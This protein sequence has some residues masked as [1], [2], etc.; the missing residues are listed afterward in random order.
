MND[1]PFNFLLFNINLR[2]TLERNFDV[3]SPNSE[4]HTRASR[5][6]QYEL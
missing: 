3:K 5:I 1:F 2:N 4:M 6:F